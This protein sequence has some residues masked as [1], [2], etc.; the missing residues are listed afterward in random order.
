VLHKARRLFAQ[1]RFRNPR[2][3]ASGVLLRCA[4]A[5]SVSLKS[6]LFSHWVDCGR[7]RTARIGAGS[8]R[9][10]ERIS[11]GHPPSRSTISCQ[12]CAVVLHLFLPRSIGEDRRADRRSFE[13]RRSS[14]RERLTAK[15]SRPEMAPQRLEKIE[16]GPGNGRGSEAS[17]LQD[18][19][20]G[21][22]PTVRD[23]G[24][25]AAGMTKS[26]CCRKRRLML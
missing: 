26:Q 5:L 18:V 19:V 13:P 12:G 20:H 2:G 25:R 17:D 9:L 11:D 22:R 14:R 23:S 8:A 1:S 21:W 15:R 7:S 24:S 10:F 4:R 16:S 3:M 6:P